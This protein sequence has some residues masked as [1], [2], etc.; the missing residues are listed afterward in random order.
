MSNQLHIGE[1][2][3]VIKSGDITRENT[4]TDLAVYASHAPTIAR[5]FGAS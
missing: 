5:E 3:I 2:L 1:T 4:D